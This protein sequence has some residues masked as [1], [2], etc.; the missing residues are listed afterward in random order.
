MYS[1]WNNMF[2]FL[3]TSDAHHDESHITNL[4]SL[5]R[6]RISKQAVWRCKPPLWHISKSPKRKENCFLEL[7]V[8]KCSFSSGILY[9]N[10]LP[11]EKCWPKKWLISSSTSGR[12]RQNLWLNDGS[13]WLSVCTLLCWC[14]LTLSLNPFLRLSFIFY[15][16]I[17]IVK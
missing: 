15:V 7:M 1:Q 4:S 6:G 16:Y 17:S 10:T 2:K 5:P 11:S 13:L 9:V 8:R 12:I 14:C 3:P